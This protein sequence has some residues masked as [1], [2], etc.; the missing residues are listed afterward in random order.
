MSAFGG[1]RVNVREGQGFAFFL[2]KHLY[3]ETIEA[4]EVRLEETTCKVV[5]G[6]TVVI[7]PGCQIDLVEYVDDFKHAGGA[8]GTARKVEGRP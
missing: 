4:D 7:G 6:K 1:E 5:R 3:A 8:V 2:D